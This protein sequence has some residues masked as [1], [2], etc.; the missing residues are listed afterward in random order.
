M[1]LNKDNVISSPVD[2]EKIWAKLV[3]FSSYSFNKS[4]SVAYAFVAYQTAKLW[5][6]H[7]GEFLEMQL[8]YGGDKAKDA[9]D[10]LKELNYKIHY[11]TYSNMKGTE[12]KIEGKDVFL[13]GGAERNYKSVIQM[14]VASDWSG[15][16]ILK[17]VCDH[18]SKDREALL[19]L[20]TSILKTGKAKLEWAEDAENNPI[21]NLNKLLEAMLLSECI[22]KYE[23]EVDDYGRSTGNIKVWVKK[24]RNYP[25]KLIVIHNNF[26]PEVSAQVIKYDK[27]FFGTVRGGAIS[28]KP[29][30]PLYVRKFGELIE[31]AKNFKIQRSDGS[32][33]QGDRQLNYFLQDELKERLRENKIRIEDVNPDNPFYF[34]N[35]KVIVADVRRFET[36]TKV[37]VKFN[38][39]Q[40]FFYVKNSQIDELGKIKN[41][42]MVLIDLM[43][44]PFIKF[45]TSEYVEDFDIIK[46]RRNN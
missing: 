38:S 41:G 20:F 31:K 35:L 39:G 13:P 18:I 42:E 6:L 8:N 21:N 4:H 36:S 9:A 14:I 2:P 16:L 34:S 33:K 11:P 24:S 26:S 23:N 28:E 45:K 37:T 12:V 22:T 44:S 32:L 43:F 7:Q 40:D 15:Q 5:A 19:D 17:G 1:K 3:D 46:I 27:K 29:E 30:L 25:D 10:K